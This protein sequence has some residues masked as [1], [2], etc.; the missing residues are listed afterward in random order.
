MDLKVSFDFKRWRVEVVIMAVED[1]GVEVLL[2]EEVVTVLEVVGNITIQEV[3]VDPFPF[4]FQ[5]RVIHLM[6]MVTEVH[7]IMDLDTI[8][9]VEEWRP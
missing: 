4:S 8:D 2:R 7:P 1:T 5:D 9:Q 3:I 6:D